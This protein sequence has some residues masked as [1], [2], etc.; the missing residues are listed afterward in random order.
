MKRLTA[1]Q[2]DLVVKWAPWA[3]QLAAKVAPYFSREERESQAYLGLCLAARRFNPD[4][5]YH[6]TTYAYRFVSGRVLDLHRFPLCL[7]M[8]LLGEWDVNVR[9]PGPVLEPCDMLTFADLVK[10]LP[11]RSRKILEL[12]MSGC[13][14]QE[15]GSALKLTRERIRQLIDAALG[16]LKNR[17]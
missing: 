6:F 4:R 13:T 7:D 10:T 9:D 3:R 15:I 11:P 16:D 5:G 1:K 8:E 2:Q 17:L 14:Y 12:R